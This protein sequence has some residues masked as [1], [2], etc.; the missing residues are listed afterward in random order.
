MRCIK[1]SRQNSEVVQFIQLKA[2]NKARH[3]QSAGLKEIAKKGKLKNCVIN[4]SKFQFPAEHLLKM[5]K[6]SSIFSPIEESFEQQSSKCFSL[7]SMEE[8]RDP[9]IALI[10]VSIK[11]MKTFCVQPQ[12]TFRGLRTQ[13]CTSIV[14]IS[15]PSN[16]Y[17]IISLLLLAL[18]LATKIDTFQL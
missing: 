3:Y 11:R 10:D 12:A 16:L 1:P 8:K 7:L 5:K 13:R 6:F 17:S 9:D 15:A 18:S 4:N 14:P 2:L